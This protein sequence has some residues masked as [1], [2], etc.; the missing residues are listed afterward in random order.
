MSFNLSKVTHCACGN[1]TK[2]VTIIEGIVVGGENEEPVSY[3]D[4][5]YDGRAVAYTDENGKFSL[6]IPAN[7]TRVIVTFTDSYYEEF[8]ERSKVFVIKEGSVGFHKVKLKRKP[9][10]I[11]F[12]A[13]QPL[14]VSLGGDPGD[15]FADLELPEDSFL[16]EDGSIFQ[17]NAK[18]TISVTDSRN[19]SD[20]L[21][22]PGDFSTTDE[23]GEAEILETYGMVKLK[24]EDDSGKQLALSKPMKVYL[25]PEKLNLT[26]QNASDVPLKLY[27]LDK[28]TQRWREVGDFQLEGGSKRRRKRD[29]RVFF[30]GTVTPAIAREQLNFDAP[31]I[32]VAVRVT[33]DPYPRTSGTAGVVVRVIRQEGAVYRGYIEKTTTTAGLVC[34]PIWRDKTCHIQA[35][36]NGQYMI[37]TRKDDL[38]RYINAQLITKTKTSTTIQWIQFESKL[39]ENS[40]DSSPMYKHVTS[41][42]AKC[43]SS[44]RRPEGSQFTF[45]EPTTPPADFS[46]FHKYKKKLWKPGCYIKIKIS[47]ENAIFAAESYKENDLTESGKIGLHIRMSRTVTAGGSNRIVCL[48]I[49]CPIKDA[50]YTYVKIAP[51]TK[52]CKFQSVH[53]G[54]SNVQ[55]PKCP[56]EFSR[57]VCAKKPPVIQ[58]QEKWVW[59]PKSGTGQT[60]YRTFND[61]QRGET[62][63][64]VG[65]QDYKDPLPDSIKNKGYALEYDCR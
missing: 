32:R 43:K 37:P 34:I 33:T 59:I 46:Y 41:E 21:T 28:K 54:L 13:S 62:K 58:G 55:Y 51:L 14:N 7:S 12:D 64:L 61:F 57:S 65:E 20:V 27:W 39:D 30:V 50:A 38:P 48:Q 25:D 16:T 24:F 8:E 15:S 63:C 60:N 19:L 2:K 3:G 40:A 42:V 17:G 35:E 9:P 36:Y 44:G 18:A 5:I 10:P 1:C 23:E 56:K 31:S 29:N 45:K 52:R 11:I 47:G 53:T 4:V 6:T 22:A 26:V 49:S